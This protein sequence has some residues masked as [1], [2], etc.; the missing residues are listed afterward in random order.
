MIVSDRNPENMTQFKHWIYTFRVNFQGW[1]LPPHSP[2]NLL[3]VF[4]CQLDE[5]YVFPDNHQQNAAIFQCHVNTGIY[6]MFFYSCIIDV[7]CRKSNLL[8]LFTYD[9]YEETIEKC[10][11]SN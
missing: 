5:P 8:L 4:G 10:I 3:H 6:E 1:Y 11:N 2:F 7:F 9:A